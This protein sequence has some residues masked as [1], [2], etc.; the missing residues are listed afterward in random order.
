[1]IFHVNLCLYNE[2]DIHLNTQFFS[3]D[4]GIVDDREYQIGD[5]HTVSCVIKDMYA[6]QFSTESEINEPV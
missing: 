3:V 4:N 5:D 6:W 1:M 2:R